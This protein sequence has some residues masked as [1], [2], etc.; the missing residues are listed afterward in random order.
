MRHSLTISA[1]IGTLGFAAPAGAVDF[2]KDVLPTLEAKCMKCHL[3]PYKTA[4]GR[5]KKPKGD[6]I[7]STAEGL[8]AGGED[9]D[10]FKGGD[11]KKSLGYVRVTLDPDD[12][13][14]MPPKDKADP[15]TETELKALKEW[16]EAGAD[17]GDWKESKIDK[18]GKPIKE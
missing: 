9:G 14:F 5:T 13:D 3:P 16:I 8:K 1:V 7:M 11:L 18:D 6:L 10:V 2:K 17:Y 4:S 12:D 15:L